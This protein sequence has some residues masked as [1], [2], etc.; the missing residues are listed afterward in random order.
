METSFKMAA[1]RFTLE[2]KTVRTSFLELHTSYAGR[3]TKCKSDQ[4]WLR[5]RRMK[6]PFLA[7]WF[8]LV[9][10]QSKIIIYMQKY[11]EIDAVCDVISE[12]SARVLDW[13]PT[14]FSSLTHQY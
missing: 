2:R 1:K 5:Y 7:I 11:I 9:Y 8:P 12:K 14:F 13:H 4:Y 6:K 3:Q 10:F